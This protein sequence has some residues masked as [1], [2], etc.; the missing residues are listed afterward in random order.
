MNF[1]EPYNENTPGISLRQG[2]SQS[3]ETKK[4]KIKEI[5]SSRLPD[6]R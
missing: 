4:D 5:K 2:I 6:L 1:P 3:N